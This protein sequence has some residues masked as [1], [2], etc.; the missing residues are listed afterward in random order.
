VAGEPV[1]PAVRRSQRADFQSDAALP[2]A[3]RL[4]RVPRDLAAEVVALADLR[5]LCSSVDV[6]GPGFINLAVDDGALAALLN[7][8]AGD[9]RLGVAPPERR[10]TVVVDYSAPNVA[11]ELHVGHI[12]S[13]II[14][15]A[16]V[17]LLEWLGHRVVRANHL[18]DWGTPFGMLIEHLLD[19]GESEA[20]HE[21]SVGDLDSF[22]RAARVKFEAD[23]AFARRARL[24]VVALQGG[25]ERTHRLWRLLVEESE[26]YFLG[27][28]HKLDITLSERDFCGESFYNDL[29]APVAE[30]LDRLALLRDSDGAACVFPTG[31]TGRDGQ[32]LPIIVRKGDGGFGY[33]ATDLAAIRYRAQ[34]LGA[35][36]L[37]YVVGLPQRQHLEMVFQVA[38]EA[39]WLRSPVRAEHVGF[40]S[41]LGPDGKI[42]RSR[43]GGAVKL[44][45]L[46]DE[47]IGRAAE[48]ARQKTPDLGEPTLGEV[49]RA[50]GIGAVKYA[51]L[52]TDRTRDYV[53][54]WQRMLSLDGNTAPYLQYA[55]ARVGSIFARAGIDAA[56][57]GAIS[58]HEPAEHALAL[59]L[60][61]FGTVID[62]VEQTL[63]FH[64]LA[65]YLYGVA[66]AFSRFFVQCPVLRAQP[67][68][69]D[70]R[71]R[72]CD[73]T[74]RILR[75][76]L[77][78]LG[79]AAP[80]RM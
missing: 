31:F 70:S 41:I 80:D 66:T 64:R 36:R 45:A 48:V 78:L 34:E 12:R 4:G 25:D 65:A 67:D 5:G 15:D 59:E 40:G 55:H 53:F 42:L 47:A 52:S 74:A 77:Y 1:D 24:R 69:R 18:G 26:K 71:L 29:L 32:P 58:I 61:A 14:G 3:R 46:L 27:V 79:I 13:T 51:D 68:I 73:L 20:A 16:V 2:L 6:S 39:G 23:D 11:K 8:Q 17:R 21:L 37:L 62:A 44:I 19:L 57:E 28:Y 50:I 72:L 22:Y 7:R 76:G 43:A 9:D 56:P 54:D 35:T 60:V 63:E 33:G 38:R 30:E 10:E 49:A 75:V